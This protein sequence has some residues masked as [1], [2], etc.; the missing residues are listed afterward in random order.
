[1]ENKVLRLGMQSKTSAVMVMI[2][3]PH[4]SN[5]KLERIT[6]SNNESPGS[7]TVQER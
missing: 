6:H 4:T 2:S 7:G 3:N 5:Y 1:M